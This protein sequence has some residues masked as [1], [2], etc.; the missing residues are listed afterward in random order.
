MESVNGILEFFLDALVVLFI[1]LVRNFK[2]SGNA[3]Q[4][5]RN[6]FA[7]VRNLCVWAL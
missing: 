4:D 2:R 7:N 5:R 1:R 3:F 6:Y